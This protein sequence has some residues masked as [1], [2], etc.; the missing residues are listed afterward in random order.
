LLA[1]E[2]LGL[3][4]KMDEDKNMFMATAKA[5]DMA[6]AEIKNFIIKND[7]VGCLSFV[8]L[9]SRDEIRRTKN[10]DWFFLCLRTILFGQHNRHFC[11]PFFFTSVRKLAV[12]V[13]I[14]RM[15]LDKVT[16]SRWVTDLKRSRCFDPCRIKK[17]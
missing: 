12:L 14:F 4:S 9:R 17:R 15:H 5:K 3:L 11:V 6:V 2:R 10:V 8:S 1:E 13:T 16:K 7:E